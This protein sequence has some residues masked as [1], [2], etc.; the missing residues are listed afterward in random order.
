MM[1]LEQLLKSKA[2]YNPRKISPEEYAALRRSLRFFGFV[3]PVVWNR[4]STNL[5]G[6]HQ[7]IT[8]AADEGFTEAPT[9]IVD[10]DDASERQLNLALNRI[11]GDWDDVKLRELLA[12]LD[13]EGADLALTGFDEAELAKL[14][15]DDSQNEEAEAELGALEYR[16]V[17]DCTGEHEQA[18]LLAKLEGEGWKCRALIS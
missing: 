11:T 6:G 4:R 16:V 12:G 9:M 18:D 10:L 14:L 5:V 15:A 7:R 8:A 1:P 17:V 3:D 13:S 2:K